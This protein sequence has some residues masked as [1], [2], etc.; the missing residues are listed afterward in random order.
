MQNQIHSRDLIVGLQKGLALIQLFS[1]EFP[2]LTVPQAAKMSGLTPS[3]ARRFFLTL[4]HERYLQ[5][6][7]RHYWLTPKALRL[8][9]AYVDSAQF[10]RMVRPIVEYIASR[11]EEHASVGVIDDDELVYIARSKHTPFNS[12]SVRLGERVPIYCTAG[13]RLWLASLAEDECE[14]VLQRIRREQRTPYTVTDVAALMEKIAQV[15]HGRAMPR[16]SRSLKLAC[17][18]W[19]CRCPTGKGSTG[20]R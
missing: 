13:G 16:L 10:P 15:R 2:R 14:T 6:D 7:G 5:T 9:Q 1:K 4:L 8:G 20:G 19:R 17:W 12:T 11:T 18:C 3:A